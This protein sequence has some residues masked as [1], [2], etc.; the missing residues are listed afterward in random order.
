MFS[1]VCAELK[2]FRS[3]FI[4]PDHAQKKLMASEDEGKP[5]YKYRLNPTK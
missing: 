2:L 1:Q 3:E 5:E 4:E